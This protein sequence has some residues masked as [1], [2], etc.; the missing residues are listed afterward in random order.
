MN[1]DQENFHEEA[2]GIKVV[3]YL[4]RVSKDHDGEVSVVLK[5]PSLYKN[6]AMNL[7][8]GVNF[9]ITFKEFT[10]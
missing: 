10:E 7:P 8:E 9:E 4:W 2:D 3:G 6:F 5:V 1:L